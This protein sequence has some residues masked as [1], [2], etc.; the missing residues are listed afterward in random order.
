[1]S[2]DQIRS[3]EIFKFNFGANYIIC[4]S[5]FF[6]MCSFANFY[7]YSVINHMLLEI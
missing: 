6:Q 4:V 2:V 3:H 5:Q 7:L 1:M